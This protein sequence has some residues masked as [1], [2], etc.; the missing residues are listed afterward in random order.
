M[1]GPSLFFRCLL[2]SSAFRSCGFGRHLHKDIHCVQS[3]GKA[4]K[5]IKGFA[6][7]LA[8]FSRS[9]ESSVVQS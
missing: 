6:K 1:L 4:R 7:S 8:I 2:M 9:E 3:D 5:L